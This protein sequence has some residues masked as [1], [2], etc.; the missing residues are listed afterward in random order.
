MTRILL[1]RVDYDPQK[2]KRDDQFA[3]KGDQFSSCPFRQ[4]VTMMH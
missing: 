1:K 3:K 2:V 4:A